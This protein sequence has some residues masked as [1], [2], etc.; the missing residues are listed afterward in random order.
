MTMPDKESQRNQIEGIY[1]DKWFLDFIGDKGE[2]MIFY[3][4]KLHWGLF[5]VPYTS[6]MQYIPGAGV[7]IRSRFRQVS[8]PERTEDQ[9]QWADP[10]F[11]VQGLWKAR[12]EPVRARLFESEEGYLDWNCFQPVSHVQLKINDRVMTGTGYAEQLILTALPWKIPMDQLR[13]GRWSSEADNLVWIEL[14]KGKK[15]QWIWLNGI[16]WKEGLIEDDRIILDS[17]KIS[18]TLDRSVVL[19]SEKKIS[20]VMENLLKYLPGFKKL[21]PL[22]FLMADEC[23]WLSN[24]QL[25]RNKVPGGRGMAIHELVD[26]KPE[27]Y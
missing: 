12:T 18:L 20:S 16:Q 21:M 5:S 23:K 13:W 14:R 3:A 1:L 7:S 24:G 8:I 15:Q 22:Q 19:E 2:A 11:Q 17:G 9:I 27:I 6:W 26:F 4:A 25:T 10:L